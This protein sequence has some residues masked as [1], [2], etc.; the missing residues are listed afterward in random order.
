MDGT[1]FVAT[2]RHESS[3]PEE[4]SLLVGDV[5]YVS[6]IQGDLY[7]GR[8]DRTSEEGWTSAT[9]GYVRQESPYSRVADKSE[10]RKL[11]FR[12]IL[13]AE[14]AFTGLLK[15]FIDSVIAPLGLR[16]T[17]FKRK[18]LGESAV[19]VSFHLLQE[20]HSACSTFQQLLAVQSDAEVASAYTQFSPSLQLFAQYA[21]ENPKL[22]NTVK[23]NRRELARLVP[24][25]M[26][27]IATLIQPVEHCASYKRMLQEYFWL[28]SPS[29]E[30]ALLDAALDGLMAQTHTVEQKIREE[31]QS[32]QLLNLQ[33]QCK[34]RLAKSRL[35]TH[36]S[37]LTTY[38]LQLV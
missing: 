3:R 4:L 10:D 11:V 1:R 5:I 23:S 8:S 35:A 25:R 7:F 37:E 26:D 34:S 24:E 36:N 28:S 22:L 31:E 18:F 9:L 30:L 33:A 21:V 38:N 29:P 14:Q 6:K 12:S 15:D 20:M 19:A 32:W 2:T 16:D 13:T 27:V 17:P